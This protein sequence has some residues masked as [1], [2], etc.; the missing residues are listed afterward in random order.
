MNGTR[1]KEKNIFYRKGQPVLYRVGLY[2][3]YQVE[4][5][6]VLLTTAA[7]E[8]MKTGPWQNALAVRA[9]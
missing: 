4:D 3:Q 8:S 7:S 5:R 6:F 9:G 1:I 2:D